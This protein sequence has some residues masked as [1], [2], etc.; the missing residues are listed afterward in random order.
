MTVM[1]IEERKWYQLLDMVI[2]FLAEFIDTATRFLQE[3]PWPV[4]HTKYSEAVRKLT[5]VCN[6]QEIVTTFGIV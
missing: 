5:R 3:V 4:G 6:D 1:D 2:S